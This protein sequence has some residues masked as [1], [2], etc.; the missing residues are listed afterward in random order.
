MALETSAERGLAIQGSDDAVNRALKQV[1]T[2]IPTADSLLAALSVTA[3]D[4]AS[5]LAA[6]DAAVLADASNAVLA[7]ENAVINAKIAENT[8]VV[9]QVTA[10]KSSIATLLAGE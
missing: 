2:I 8:A 7:S 6:S 3:T 9:A 5:A 10:L 4:L 1:N